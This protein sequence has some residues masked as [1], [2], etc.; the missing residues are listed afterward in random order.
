M[1]LG[2]E[3]GAAQAFEA[4]GELD[5]AIALYRKLGQHEQAGDLLRRVGD[6]DAAQ[7]EYRLAAEV[8]EEANSPPDWLEIGRLLG[9]KAGD[10]EAAGAGLRQ[11]L[12]ACGRPPTPRRAACGCWRSQ[13]QRGEPAPIARLLDEADA[14]LRDRGSTD[15]R[16]FYGRVAAIAVASPGPALPIDDIRDRAA[17]GAGASRPAAGRRFGRPAGPGRL[18]AVQ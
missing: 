17:P 7:A 13:V 1:K 8:V 16:D 18:V 10:V 5:R 6:E 4:A 2:D 14:F 9:E 12:G 3:A 15:A 11:W